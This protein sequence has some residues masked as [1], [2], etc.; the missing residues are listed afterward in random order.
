MCPLFTPIL[1]R[2]VLPERLKAA[3]KCRAE[4]DVI[5][6]QAAKAD[7]EIV[8]LAEGVRIEWPVD[9]E[10]FQERFPT[11]VHKLEYLIG[12]VTL[13]IYTAN[14][15]A[16]HLDLVD[17]RPYWQLICVADR[18]TPESCLRNR[19]LKIWHYSDGFWSD[20]KAFCGGIECRCRVRNLTE[21]KYLREIANEK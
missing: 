3:I 12:A 8:S 6:G 18:R 5:S 1:D 21:R 16:R 2:I 13:E 9:N 11:M 10:A 14:R 4:S 15:Y 20:G 17:E 7:T 19:H